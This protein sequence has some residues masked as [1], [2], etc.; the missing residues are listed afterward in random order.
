MEI[1]NTPHDQTVT[2]V[3]E[4]CEFLFPFDHNVQLVF[5]LSFELAVFR[6][7][8]VVFLQSLYRKLSIHLPI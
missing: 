1:W 8:F 4:E 5:I 3:K 7:F 6:P 2:K